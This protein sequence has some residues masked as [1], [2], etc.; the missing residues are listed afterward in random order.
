MKEF[1]R[2]A[3]MVSGIIANL[4]KTR[5][6]LGVCLCTSVFKEDKEKLLG[7]RED[8]TRGLFSEDDYGKVA[9]MVALLP[10]LDWDIELVADA[11]YVE[12][13]SVPGD[14]F[15]EVESGIAD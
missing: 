1:S 5:D 13:H 14:V 2:F 3:D 9:A 8:L 11:L 15:K 4:V 12:T 6:E 7:E 10:K